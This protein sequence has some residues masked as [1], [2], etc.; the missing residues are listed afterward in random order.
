MDRI[1]SEAGYTLVEV[2][3]FLVLLFVALAIAAHYL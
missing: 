1:K 2:G 3:V